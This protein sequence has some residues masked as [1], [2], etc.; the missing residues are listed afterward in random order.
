MTANP[1]AAAFPLLTSNQLE[2]ISILA[3]HINVKAGARLLQEGQSCDSIYLITHGVAD[4]VKSLEEMKGVVTELKAGE[5]V[6]EMSF[7]GNFPATA[8][9]TA[10]TDITAIKIDKV[11]LMTMLEGDPALGMAF[12]RSIAATVSRRLLQ[13]TER[14]FLLRLT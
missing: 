7:A 3:E 11:K 8:T 1:L 4:L 2:Q 6:G 13:I 9:V 12:F 14:F 10:A 5:V